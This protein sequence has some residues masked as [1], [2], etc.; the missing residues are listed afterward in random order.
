MLRNCKLND[1]SQIEYSPVT[2]TW[3]KSFF[4]SPGYYLE[5]TLYLP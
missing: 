2:T 3:D 4:F 5:V 1:L